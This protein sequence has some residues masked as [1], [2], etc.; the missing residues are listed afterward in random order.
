MG[1]KWVCESRILR[2]ERRGR[3]NTSVSRKT[4][5]SDDI[6]QVNFIVGANELAFAT[7]SVRHL[8]SLGVLRAR[9]DAT[10]KPKHAFSLS[11]TSVSVLGY[12]GPVKFLFP[13]LIESLRHG[14][15]GRPQTTKITYDFLFFSCNS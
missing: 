13:V 7:V 15:Y 3:L 5:C 10:I 14:V 12:S 6:S 9:H 8:K 2:V 4:V 1:L 11:E